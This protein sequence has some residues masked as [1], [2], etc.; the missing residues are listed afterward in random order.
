MTHVFTLALPKGRIL[1][2]VLPILARADI[3]PEDDFFNDASRKLRF[4]T[5][6]AHLT[7]V[8]VRSFDVPAFVS[9]G[10]ADAGVCGFD[11]LQEFGHENMI[12]PL[13]LG[14]GRCR[15]SI[16]EPVTD[17]HQDRAYRLMPSHVTVATKYPRLTARHFAGLGIQAECVKLNGAMELAPLAG[18]SDYIVDLVSTGKTLKENGLQEC[19]KI[20]DVT[21][22]FILNRVSYKLHRDILLDI[23]TRLE[24]ALIS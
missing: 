18:I 3:T 23:T 24:S 16:A 12:A 14:I 13:D 7:L 6:H 9:R 19:E 4:A 21:S 17:K 8:R 2:E 10:A 5:N 11:V 15:L 20:L 1:K 22:R